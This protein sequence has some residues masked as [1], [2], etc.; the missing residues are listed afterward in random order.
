MWAHE[1]RCH[2]PE[3]NHPPQ[4][5]V[6]S[7]CNKTINNTKLRANKKKKTKKKEEK[8]KRDK[9]ARARQRVTEAQIRVP[10]FWSVPVRR[11]PRANSDRHLK[12]SAAGNLS[13][14][15]SSESPEM[16]RRAFS[17]QNKRA[18]KERYHSINQGAS[19]CSERHTP[20]LISYPLPRPQRTPSANLTTKKA[21]ARH[22]T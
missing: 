9:P 1:R 4:T 7:A 20:V 19:L 18:I 15:P 8:E 2:L 21:M 13:L 22:L 11:S 14:S 16:R 3:N 5:G 10:A 17:P 6:D 12:I